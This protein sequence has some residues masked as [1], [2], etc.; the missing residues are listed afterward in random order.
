MKEKLLSNIFLGKI[1]FLFRSLIISSHYDVEKKTFFNRI[2]RN[3]WN[4]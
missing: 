3:E 1:L 4:V 2:V